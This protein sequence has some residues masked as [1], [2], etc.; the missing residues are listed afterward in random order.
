M[1]RKALSGSVFGKVG[2]STHCHT[3]WGVPY[4]SGSLDKGTAMDT[5]LFFRWTGWRGT[6]SAFR[7]SP[8]GDEPVIPR[9][10][11][12]SPAHALP[13]ISPSM[14]AAAVFEDGMLARAS[15][16][17]RRFGPEAIGEQIGPARLI[18]ID[19]AP[20]ANTKTRAG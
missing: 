17:P 4:W 8:D 14:L 9:L 12:L 19:A 5:H 13:G 15:G 11:S 10:A 18:A 2:Y 16:P 20:P 1:A 3:D 7:R 6:P